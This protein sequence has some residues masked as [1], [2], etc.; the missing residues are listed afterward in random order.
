MVPRCRTR[1]LSS[2]LVL[3]LFQNPDPIPGSCSSSQTMGPG[4]LV[5]PCERRAV[6]GLNLSGEFHSLPLVL[7]WVQDLSCPIRTKQYLNSP[8][9]ICLSCCS[10]DLLDYRSPPRCKDSPLADPVS[11]VHGARPGCPQQRV[12]DCLCPFS[13]SV[14]KEAGESFGKVQFYVHGNSITEPVSVSGAISC[15]Y[16]LITQYHNYHCV[17]HCK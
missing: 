6:F 7:A 2:I 3:F 14:L 10:L 11:A 4:S 9:C 15:H 13:P 1:C 17:G 5:P 8:R 16:L 12:G